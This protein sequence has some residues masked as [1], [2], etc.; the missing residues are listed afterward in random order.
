MDPAALLRGVGEHVAERR[1][2]AEGAVAGHQ[3]GAVEAAVA[4]IAQHGR[5]GLC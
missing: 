1:P 5:P 2:R 3:L 4:E